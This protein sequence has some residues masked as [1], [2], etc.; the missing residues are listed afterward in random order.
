MLSTELC[1]CFSFPFF[2]SSPYQLQLNCFIPLG[3]LS[4]RRR[5]AS[6]FICIV[7]HNLLH[8]FG[9]MASSRGG[10]LWDWKGKHPNRAAFATPAKTFVS[11]RKPSMHNLCGQ[12]CMCSWRWGL[13]EVQGP[14]SRALA[15]RCGRSPCAFS[16]PAANVFP[17]R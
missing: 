4:E 13:H 15:L 10:D 9:L 17:V 14:S 2:L 8:L 7:N 5:C 12:A 11:L 1:C 16:A 6:S 3:V